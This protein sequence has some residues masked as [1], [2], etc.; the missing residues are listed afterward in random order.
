M[1]PTASVPAGTE[2]LTNGLTDAVVSAV[3][4]RVL[5]SRVRRG[6]PGVGQN[7]VDKLILD[8]I[9]REQ[10]AAI[11]PE[12]TK[13]ILTTD[14]K[15]VPPMMDNVSTRPDLAKYFSRPEIMHSLKMQRDIQTPEFT[16]LSEIA[17]VG[18]RLR[19]RSEE[20]IIDMSDEAYLRRHRRYEAFEKKQ[21]RREK[22]KLV[23]EQYKLRQRLDE[24]RGFDINAFAVSGI[25]QTQVETEERRKI[26]LETAEALDRRYATLL[27]P[28]PKRTV[29]RRAQSVGPTAARAQSVGPSMSRAMMADDPPPPPKT[30]RRRGGTPA[31]TI[32]RQELHDA[33]LYTP[34]SDAP[35]KSTKKSS[36][37]SSK[38]KSS[39]GTTP[40]LTIKL[41]ARAA[42]AA[43]AAATSPTSDNWQPMPAADSDPM[44][45]TYDPESSTTVAAARVGARRM[46]APNPP[47]KRAR[48]SGPAPPA[49]PSTPSVGPNGV[50]A[51]ILAAKRMAQPKS[52]RM[53]RL[54]DPFGV[55][56]PRSVGEEREFE[57]PVWAQV[58][59]EEPE[60]ED[61]EDA[62]VNSPPKYEGVVTHGPPPGME[63]D[64]D[65]EVGE[66]E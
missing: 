49:R 38:P 3:N 12:T 23:H 30:P 61:D 8:T 50:P 35:P 25:P 36:K 24:L 46:S 57:I 55:K 1:A 4:K 34:G 66:I 14:S 48:T 20:N 32:A 29:R 6:G 59:Y 65:V 51:L 39:K 11:I 41:P 40:K 43:T 5:P 18:G 52:R 60:D 26:M 45:D 27:P 28:D 62:S 16:P 17:A 13:F 19:V 31:P 37:K 47:R 58:G 2:P 9:E 33:A 63:M 42:D 44:D 10:E 56:M 22:E 21:R 64:V 7:D 15:L 54:P 53:S